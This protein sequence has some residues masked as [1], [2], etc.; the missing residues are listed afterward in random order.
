MNNNNHRAYA[1][2]AHETEICR[3]GRL[4]VWRED[5]RRRSIRWARCILEGVCFAFLMFGLIALCAIA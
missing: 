4:G 2:R 3:G 1:Y 5:N